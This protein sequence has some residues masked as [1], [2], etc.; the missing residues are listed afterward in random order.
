MSW[1]TITE[2]R[3]AILSKETKD[4]WHQLNRNYDRKFYK[5]FFTKSIDFVKNNG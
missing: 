4:R 3:C 2:E 1:F 5:R